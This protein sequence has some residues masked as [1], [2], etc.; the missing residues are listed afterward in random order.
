MKSKSS[1]EQ[2]FFTV[3]TVENM[4][5]YDTSI[6]VLNYKIDKNLSLAELINSGGKVMGDKLYKNAKKEIEKTIRD[7]LKSSSTFINDLL[8]QVATKWLK[9]KNKSTDAKKK[10]REKE[11]Q[12]EE[13]DVEKIVENN[14]A[15][16][17][18]EA[19]IESYI[20][21]AV[22]E[23]ITGFKPDM[24]KEVIV[25]M[26]KDKFSLGYY[27]PVDKSITLLD[28]NWKAEDLE[29][30]M[31]LFINEA[32]LEPKDRDVLS[33]VG[34]LSKND[35]W[36]LYFALSYPATAMSHEIEHARRGDE[37]SKGGHDDITVSLF[38][39]Q[40]PVLKNYSQ[41]S[42]EV[43][44]YVLAHGFYEN[45]FDKISDMKN[46]K[47]RNKTPAAKAVKA[48]KKVAKAAK[49]TKKV[50]KAKK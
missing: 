39:G 47:I 36:S 18:F 31:N 4:L 30:L 13:L 19:W 12:K 2:L 48:S 34:K 6:I 27:S 24:V 25:K 28:N 22:K 45:F 17:F 33:L 44:Q 16:P 42:N 29:Q 40:P 20:E 26:D 50:A 32:K 21:I 1:M 37:H 14:V 49:T 15:Q 11:K 7:G 5:N 8:F 38:P 9:P 3:Y 35:L 43:Y 23:K 41:C 10:E 46:V